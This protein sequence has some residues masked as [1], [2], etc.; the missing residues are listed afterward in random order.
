M[1]RK[2]KVTYEPLF[3]GEDGPKYVYV[4]DETDGRSKIIG[5][6][7]FEEAKNIEQ[8]ISY[9]TNKELA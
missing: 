2:I 8:Q 4:W 7:S 9:L 3:D 5:S 1:E 6:F